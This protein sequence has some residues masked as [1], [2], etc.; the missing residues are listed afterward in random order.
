MYVRLPFSV[1][2]TGLID[3]VIPKSGKASAFTVSLAVIEVMPSPLAVTVLVM[4][5]SLVRGAY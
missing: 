4:N 2:G 5:D 1:T 3:F